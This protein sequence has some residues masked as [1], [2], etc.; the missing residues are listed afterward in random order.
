MLGL[1]QGEALALRWRDVDLEVRVLRVDEAVQRVKGQGLRFKDT[2]T[3]QSRTIPLPAACVAALGEHLCRQEVERELAGER[4]REHDLVFC[5]R[6]GTPLDGTNVS[7]YFKGLLKRAG[8]ADGRAGRAGAR[9]DGA[10]G[11]LGHPAHDE[12]LHPRPRR[13]EAARGRRDG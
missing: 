6:H 13:G 9:G 2:K 12:R 7:R 4:W 11:P 1:R 8:V 5:T 3:H 10:P